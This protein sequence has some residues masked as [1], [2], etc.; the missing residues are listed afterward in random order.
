MLRG[1]AAARLTCRAASSSSGCSSSSRSATTLRGALAAR[2]SAADQRHRRR[3]RLAR[4]RRVGP[5][6]AQPGALGRVADRRLEPDL[7]RAGV[8]GARVRRVSRL[9][10]R[11]LAG[12][13]GAGGVGPRRDRLSR[14]RGC[15]AVAGRRAALIGGALL[16]TN[17]VCVMWNRAALMEAT[18]A[19]FIVVGWAAYALARAPAGLG[20][21]SPA[22][23]RSLA[24]FT[25]AS[26][27]FFA[28]GARA[29]CADDACLVAGTGACGRGRGRRR[30][31]D[32]RRARRSCT[33]AGLALAA[34]AV[35][36][37]VRLAALDRL[38]VLQLADVGDAQAEL[39]PRGASSIARRGC[40]S[41]RLL[42]AHVAASWPRPRSRCSA[43]VAAVA[44]ARPAER[45]LVLWMLLGVARTHRARRR[46]T[47]GAS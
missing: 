10:R 38:P 44:P 11:P 5:Q 17:Y 9:R 40:R 7:H 24:F 47:S 12:A 3:H 23:R 28:G 15:A 41:S 37:L 2:R 32:R 39:R 33:L 25:K 46:A 14:W 45:L 30:R 42:H 22:S 18:M 6:R 26:A 4:R 31:A 36:A 13:A 21:R 16:A 20:R 43:I 27:A 1:L 19:A 34:V 35:L 29:R 8:H